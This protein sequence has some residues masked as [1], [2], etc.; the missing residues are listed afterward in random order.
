MGGTAL[1]SVIAI[2]QTDICAP[3]DIPIN[4]AAVSSGVDGTVRRIA[5]HRTISHRPPM[6]VNHEPGVKDVRLLA[7]KL[8]SWRIKTPSNRMIDSHLIDPAGRR[9]TEAK[10]DQRASSISPA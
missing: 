5:I 10:G 7:K 2:R 4:I 9:P 1:I 3:S 6:T 8:V